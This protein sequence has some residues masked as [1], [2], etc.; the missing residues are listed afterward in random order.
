M[1]L[2]IVNF[3]D[4]NESGD[5]AHNEMYTTYKSAERRFRTLKRKLNRYSWVRIWNT[6]FDFG[7]VRYNKCVDYCLS[8]DGND[9][10]YHGDDCDF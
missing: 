1:E 10:Y 5:V 4:A 9:N 8:C 3:Y 7:R 2:Y 6:V